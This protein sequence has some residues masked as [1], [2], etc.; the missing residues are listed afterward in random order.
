[1]GF[2]FFRFFLSFCVFTFLIHFFVIL[3]YSKIFSVSLNGHKLSKCLRLIFFLHSKKSW[4][5]SIAWTEWELAELQ[6]GV[7]IP[8]GPSGRPGGNNVSPWHGLRL[9]PFL[10]IRALD[11][12]FS[13]GRISR[14]NASAFAGP[15]KAECFARVFGKKRR[16]FGNPS[17]PTLYYMSNLDC[18]VFPFPLQI[19]HSKNTVSLKTGM[20][21]GN[22]LIRLNPFRS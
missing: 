20:S 7:R 14:A 1:M 11:P 5:R 17:D 19:R 3:F 8:A 16:P 6:T 9:A 2:F 13:V 4:S 18:V 21:S 12:F 22:F 10:L 15:R